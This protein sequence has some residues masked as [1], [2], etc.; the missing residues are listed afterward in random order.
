MR[1]SVQETPDHCAVEFAMEMLGGRWKLAILKQLTAGTH[2][3]GALMRAL[4]GISQRMLTRQLRELEADGLVTRTVY[5]EVPP[6]VE[7]ALTEV[8]HSLDS[9][10]EELDK[11]G[12]WYRET[13]RPE[14]PSGPRPSS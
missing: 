1:S 10:T 6:R 12:R 13:V 11:W 2:R 3:F 5:R 14:A 7:Y 9:I 4:P 8:G